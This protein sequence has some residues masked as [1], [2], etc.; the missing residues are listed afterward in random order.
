[1]PVR[2]AA[3]DH[4][5][6]VLSVARGVR[7]FMPDDEGMALHRAGRIGAAIGPVVEIGSYCGRSTVWLGFAAREAA[8]VCF[9][10]DHHRGSEELQPGWEHH[11]PTVVDPRTGRTDTL[12]FLR[13]TVEQAGLEDHVVIVVGDSA[14]V[15]AHWGTALGMVFI[16]GGHDAGPA[17]ADY[18][19]WSPQ[20]TVGGLLAIHDVFADPAGGG[21]APYEIFC[22]AVVSGS[23]VEEPALGCGS[24]RVLR[25]TAGG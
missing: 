13:H 3:V 24:L 25:R 14:L 2:P 15:A 7:G 20:V 16:D 19:G 8:T 9:T 12:P 17:H 6:D 22:R 11:D 18:D 4:D 1:M 10:V 23:F 5:H 21:R